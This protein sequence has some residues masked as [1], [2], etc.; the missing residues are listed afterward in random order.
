MQIIE[1]YDT[2]ETNYHALCHE[3]AKKFRAKFTGKI[4]LT[5]FRTNFP[6]LYCKVVAI[7]VIEGAIKFINK[8]NHGI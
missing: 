2:Q 7:G 8:I 1:F 3:V 4:N 5:R 6:E